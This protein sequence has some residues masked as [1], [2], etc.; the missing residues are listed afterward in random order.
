MKTRALSAALLGMATLVTATV[1]AAPTVSCDPAPGPT[2]SP[3]AFRQPAGVDVGVALSSGSLHAL[4]EIGVLEA[5]EDAGIEVRAVS[6]TSA[7]ALVGALWASGMPAREIEGMAVSGS[8]D[9]AG[10]VAPSRDGLLSNA[11]LRRQLEDQFAGRPIE[12]WP[13][14]FA[15]VATNVSN[16]HSRML[17]T[18]DAALAVQASSAVP[19]LYG[20]VKVGGE[21]LADGALVEPVPVATARALGA[22]FVI[23]VDVNYRPYEDD[24]AGI[25]GLGFQAMHI[26][27]NALAERQRADADFVVGL[28]VHALMK[29]GHAALVA[30]G[31]DAMRRVLPDLQAALERKAAA[32][33]AP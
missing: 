25:V 7:G 2:P 18:G 30:G 4:S 16:G 6:G 26:L 28:D 21:R 10:P 22:D 5:L 31:R 9:D 14:R 19:V 17:M 12:T 8:W 29:C 20:P 23:A 3:R 27:V 1:L 11:R 24:A 15:A 33:A 32:M 13:R